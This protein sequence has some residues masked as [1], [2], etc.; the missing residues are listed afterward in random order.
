[1]FRGLFM[2]I[3]HPKLT[4][5]WR[6]WVSFPDFGIDKIKAK[7]D[8]GARSSSL[9]AWKIRPFQKDG[10]DW[11]RF[12]LH[13]LQRTNKITCQCE[14]R[15]IE[16]RKIKSSSGHE[17]LRYII[18]SKVVMGNISW[19][20]ELALG[21]R[22]AMGFRLLLGRTAVR[23]RFLVDAGHSYLAGNISHPD[24]IHSGRVK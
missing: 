8:T 15:V 2:K 22:D 12:E 23:N 14:A 5:G 20:I 1:M 19:P 7:I 4:I 21:N 9:H 11:V 10:V 6:E 16:Q 17:T 13:P 24:N 18:S 3:E